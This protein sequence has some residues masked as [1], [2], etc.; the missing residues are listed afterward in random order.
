MFEASGVIV[1]PPFAANLIWNFASEASGGGIAGL[2]GLGS[3]PEGV[4]GQIEFGMRTQAPSGNSLDLGVSYDGIGAN[5][6]NSVTGR[7]G[8]RFPLN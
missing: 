1:E 6:Y 8:V 2:D 3:G 5:D 4:R 7:A